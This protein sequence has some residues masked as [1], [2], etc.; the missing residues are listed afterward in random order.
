MGYSMSEEM[1]KLYS[2]WLKGTIAAIKKV[3]IRAGITNEEFKAFLN[4]YA[5]RMMDR[6]YLQNLEDFLVEQGISS[7]IAN[8]LQYVEVSEMSD[9]DLLNL[10]SGKIKQEL[11][12]VM[13]EEV[14]KKEDLE[15]LLE[16]L[17]TQELRALFPE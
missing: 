10:I 7:V 17:K 16:A 2:A 14:Q 11:A 9:E 8:K 1:V 12:K 4:Y 3:E 5:K 6:H 13:T 15:A